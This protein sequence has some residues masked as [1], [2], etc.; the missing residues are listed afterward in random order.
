MLQ[1]SMLPPVSAEFLTHLKGVFKFPEIHMLDP[2]ISREDLCVMIG[3][4]KVVAFIEKMTKVEYAPNGR[5][6]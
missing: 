1:S 4:A 5:P 6:I 3:Q 2:N